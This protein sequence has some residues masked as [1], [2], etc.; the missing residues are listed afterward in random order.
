MYRYVIIVMTGLTA[1]RPAAAE[2][3][4][5]L[6]LLNKYAETQDKMQSFIHRAAF[7]A[8]IAFKPPDKKGVWESV[9]FGE[10]DVR[11]D[12]NRTS[13]TN[14]IWGEPKPGPYVTKDQPM[15]DRNLWDGESFYQYDTDSTSAGVLHIL[16]Y[17]TADPEAKSAKARMFLRRN[18]GVYSFLGGYFYKQP[19][20]I[21]AVLR[22]GGPISV[23]NTMDSVGDSDC[24]VIEAKIKDGEYRLWIDP[25]HGY[26]IARVEINRGT[27][28]LPGLKSYFLCLENVRFR[29]VDGVWLPVE[30]D[31]SSHFVFPD[32]DLDKS[33]YHIKVTKIVLDPDHEALSSFVLGEDEIKEGTEVVNHANLGIR[34]KWEDGRAVPRIDESVLEVLDEMTH[35]IMTDE[36]EQTEIPSEGISV[37]ELLNRYRATQKKL[38]SFIARAETSTEFGKTTDKPSKTEQ[39]SCEFRF[40]GDR[41]CHRRSFWDGVVATKDRPSY[42]SFVWDGKALIQYR[43]A[44]MPEYSR[45]FIT[46]DDQ[47]KKE[48]IATEYSGAPLMGILGGDY[49]R[50]DFV[51]SKAE[52]ISLRDKNEK[53]GDSDCYVIDAVTKRG[54]YTLW[55]DP[56]HG[57][58]IARARVERAKGDLIYDTR[59]VKTGVTFALEN[60]RFEAIG[61]VW[62]PMEAQM[63]ENEG[64]KVSKRH[65]KRLEMLLNPDHDGLCSFV[66]DDIPEGTKVLVAGALTAQY[67]WQSGKVVAEDG[68]DVKL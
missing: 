42:K 17:E 48:M 67:K 1:L 9:Y 38:K 31:T 23:R 44:T 30:A 55:M 54:K 33:D 27:G 60:V 26:N 43:Q 3:P 45:V 68:S 36:V 34:Y 20:R 61:G 11:F 16:A 2:V 56:G 24:Y 35:E 10:E 65:H 4:N 37:S 7:R 64:A 50:V 46:K 57:Y 5:A 47:R 52:T 15:Y 18:T 53:M 66:A 12:G 49:E 19:E 29:E 21:D 22:K 39:Q 63:Q 40:D 28:D 8:E 62:V 32:G 25:K 58:N 14:T 59:P 6:E 13:I 51:L 41:V